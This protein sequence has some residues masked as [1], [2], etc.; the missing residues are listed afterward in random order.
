MGD[1]NGPEHAVKTGE[2]I[3]YGFLN[4]CTKHMTSLRRDHTLELCMVS[5]KRYTTKMNWHNGDYLA[6]EAA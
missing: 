3:Y 1:R 4:K 2:N 5:A 6:Y